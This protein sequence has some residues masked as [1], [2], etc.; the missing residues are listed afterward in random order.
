MLYSSSHDAKSNA[1]E[2]VTIQTR[3]RGSIVPQHGELLFNLEPVPEM[4]WLHLYKM[5]NDVKIMFADS[6]W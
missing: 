6:G 5:R 4:V 1:A 3:I 2:V